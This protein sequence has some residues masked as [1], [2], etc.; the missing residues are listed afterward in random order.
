MSYSHIDF[1]RVVEICWPLNHTREYPFSRI[2]AWDIHGYENI[3]AS[4]ELELFPKNL[5][6]AVIEPDLG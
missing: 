3:N 2:I 6:R 4:H 5:P 1:L